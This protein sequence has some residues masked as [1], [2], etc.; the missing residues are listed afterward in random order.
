MSRIPCDS[1]FLLILSLTPD[2]PD[3]IERALCKNHPG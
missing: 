1:V 2:S 3:S